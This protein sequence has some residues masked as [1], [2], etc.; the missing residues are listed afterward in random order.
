MAAAVEAAR[1]PRPSYRE[2]DDRDARVAAGFA[3]VM[4]GKFTLRNSGSVEDA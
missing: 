1:P 2:K 3:D 4:A